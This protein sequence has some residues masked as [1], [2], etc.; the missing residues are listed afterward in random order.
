[1]K[2]NHQLRII[3][4]EKESLGF[5]HEDPGY[6][7]EISKNKLFITGYPSHSYIVKEW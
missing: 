7:I 4:K 2:N 3:K 5:K 1:M 6:L